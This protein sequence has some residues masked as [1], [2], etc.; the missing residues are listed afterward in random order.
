MGST[1]YDGDEYSNL[2]GS[3]MDSSIPPWQD[4]RWWIRR[5]AKA[6]RVITS[7]RESVR[8]STAFRSRVYDLLT[9]N[10]FLLTGDYLN[11]L[12]VFLPLGIIGGAVGWDANAVFALNSLALNPLPGLLSFATGDLLVYIN[13][14]AEGLLNVILVNLIPLIVSSLIRELRI[15]RSAMA[16]LK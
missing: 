11:A 15:H 16:D 7:L 5:P 4:D 14:A 8:G 13:K 9:R 10:Y 2:G 12:L 3:D 1:T 6:L